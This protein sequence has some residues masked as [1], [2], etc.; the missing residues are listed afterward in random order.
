MPAPIENTI[1]D[2]G[3]S[4]SPSDTKIPLFRQQY[5]EYNSTNDD[6]LIKAVH[7]KMYSD[8]PFDDFLPAFVSKF[9][10]PPKEEDGVIDSFVKGVKG[11]FNG[12]DI[13]IYG[14]LNRIGGFAGGWNVSELQKKQEE[15][16]PTESARFE[17]IISNPTAGGIFKFLAYN[18][19]QAVP[20]IPTMMIPELGGAALG[21]KIAWSAGAGTA[22]TTML[23]IGGGALAS[24]LAMSTISA[25]DVY[26]Q[27][28]QE[29]KTEEEASSAADKTL[30]MSMP[31]NLIAG[32]IQAGKLLK[33][34]RESGIP[35]TD[36]LVKKTV[37]LTMKDLGITTITGAM[38]L[39][40]QSIAANIAL[41]HSW[42]EG[43]AESA[44]SGGVLGLGMG[45]A[46]ELM[47]RLGKHA[48]QS[49]NRKMV[50][51]G[52]PDE[53]GKPIES[54]EGKVT[55]TAEE[56]KIADQR[57]ETIKSISEPQ[58]IEEQITSIKDQL[59]TNPDGTKDRT[60][61]IRLSA[62][63]SHLEKMGKNRND[64]LAE[65]SDLYD[66]SIGNAEHEREIVKI[67]N[68][69][70]PQTPVDVVDALIGEKPKIEEP[71]TIK[72]AA[73]QAPDGTIYTGKWHPAAYEEYM[74]DKGLSKEDVIAE[75]ESGKLK[76]GF[77]TS[78]NKFV[79]RDEAA[80][81]ASKVNQFRPDKEGEIAFAGGL[82]GMESGQGIIKPV[83]DANTVAIRRMAEEGKTT[84]EIAEFTGKTEIDIRKQI[85]EDNGLTNLRYDE[86][87]DWMMGEY[88][89]A[90]NTTMVF[91]PEDMTKENL[92]KKLSEKEQLFA[93]AENVKKGKEAIETI[94]SVIPEEERDALNDVF[95]AMASTE[96]LTP[97]EFIAKRIAKVKVDEP[98]LTIHKF[99]MQEL[100]DMRHLKQGDEYVKGATQLRDD[101]RAILH[102]F[103]KKMPGVEPSDISTVLHEMFHLSTPFLNDAQRALLE[104]H[105]GIE[106]A[107]WTPEVHEKYAQMF[108]DYWKKGTAPNKELQP[109]FDRIKTFLQNVYKSI[110]EK[111]L[112]ISLPE[113]VTKVFDS[114][115]DAEKNKKLQEDYRQS[116][117]EFLGQYGE[118]IV[119]DKNKKIGFINVENPQDREYIHNQ[120]KSYGYQSED[121]LP[122]QGKNGETF[123]IAYYQNKDD[124]VNLALS[125]RIKE[126][127]GTITPK[128]YEMLLRA[129]G[130]DYETSR[131]MTEA[132]R[133]A[134]LTA[135]EK[136]KPST[137]PKTISGKREV[138]PDEL[139]KAHEDVSGINPEMIPPEVIP[140]KESITPQEIA[141]MKESGLRS[142]EGRKKTGTI[143]DVETST[144]ISKSV[145]RL[146]K[147]AESLRTTNPELADAII[148]I[149]NTQRDNPVNSVIPESGVSKELVNYV[150]GYFDKFNQ[151]TSASL[152]VANATSAE[153]RNRLRELYNEH[154]AW[155]DSDEGKLVK[156]TLKLDPDAQ[157]QYPFEPLSELDR[158][159]IYEELGLSK[160]E[161]DRLPDSNLHDM[162]NNKSMTLYQKTIG[163]PSDKEQADII[164][165]GKVIT[166]NKA[167]LDIKT[168]AKEVGVTPEQVSKHIMYAYR[169]VGMPQMIAGSDPYG[170]GKVWKL[171]NHLKEVSNGIA[172]NYLMSPDYLAFK[173]K[174]DEHVARVMK[175]RV[176]GTTWGV[177][178]YDAIEA[179]MSKPWESKDWIT[180]KDAQE[181]VKNGDITAEDATA[182]KE[183]QDNLRSQYS[184]RDK[185]V[186]K[187]FSENEVKKMGYTQ[188]EY[189]D[190][191]ML[192]EQMD[193]NATTQGLVSYWKKSAIGNGMSVADAEKTFGLTGYHP[194]GR[195]EGKWVL[196]Y[197]DP[198]SP[199]GYTFS[200]FEHA[201]TAERARLDM[202]DKGIVNPK[203][204][205]S[206]VHEVQDHILNYG[207]HMNDHDLAQLI[208]EAG[209]FNGIQERLKDP[210][211]SEEEKQILMGQN[212]L[213][214]AIKTEWKKRGYSSAR[215]IPRGNVG[216]II[217]PKSM[218]NE[219][220]TFVRTTAGR[221]SNALG[222]AQL[223]GMTAELAREVPGESYRE[224][225][226]R[227]AMAKYANQYID[228]VTRYNDPLQS[229]LWDRLRD[230]GFLWSLAFNTSNGII[231]S[232]QPLITDIPEMHK[233]R[234][235]SLQNGALLIQ[236]EKE[237]W[238]LAFGGELSPQIKSDYPGLH[239]AI[240]EWHSE[241]KLKASFLEETVVPG[242]MP[243]KLRQ[244]A[245]FPQSKSENKNRIGSSIR[246]YILASDQVIPD[247]V[248]NRKLARE[249]ASIAYIPDKA[250]ETIMLKMPFG[251]REGMT[252]DLLRQIENELYTGK[253]SESE[254]QRIA[255]KFGGKFSDDVN[256]IYGSHNRPRFITSAG[257][258]ANPLK[259]AFLFKGFTNSYIGFFINHM[260][261]LEPDKS[262]GYNLTHNLGHKAV[263]LAPLLALAGVVGLPFA[264]DIKTALKTGGVTD[265]DKDLRELV[266]NNMYSD[267]ILKGLPALL[268]NDVAPDLS[269][270]IGVGDVLPQGLVQGSL[271]QGIAS[272]FLGAPAQMVQ[273]FSIESLK[274]F[275][276]GNYTSAYQ[277][278][279]PVFVNNII[280]AVSA[281]DRGLVTRKGEMLLSPDKISAGEV[282]MQGIGFSPMHFTEARDFE[283]TMKYAEESRKSMVAGFNERLARAVASGDQSEVQDVIDDIVHHNASA[284]SPE[285]YY[286]FKKS[287]P[288][289]KSRYAE[290]TTENGMRRTPK[291]MRPMYQ[292]TKPL[293]TGE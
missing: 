202:I 38:Q 94:K 39:S 40:G 34:L 126:S 242:S 112:G 3:V 36:A 83:E 244:A 164:E 257:W 154:R 278:M 79:D 125:R 254:K 227:R 199:T 11:G 211:I 218:I 97:E 63:E 181:M 282:A 206:E 205:T 271:S 188:E 81:I 246:G 233:W 262:V 228:D 249:L 177:S 230:A 279:S 2:V 73:T 55:P 215:T 44:V 116:H 75:L 59:S 276:T 204:K 118:R 201:T 183:R 196:E 41:D 290:M 13:G 138:T 277:K 263:T 222:K 135:T 10:A 15:N 275:S 117:S 58:T 121:M 80:K 180:D 91:K 191:K 30:A 88:P 69:S 131:L 6:D 141:M 245:T 20:W 136:L 130:Y 255:T 105:S 29:G 95:K 72:S 155:L 52:I 189:N 236:S 134:Q 229:K 144:E 62:I 235:N 51:L 18:A 89:K 172:S 76:D 108:E 179:K 193:G 200:R 198:T 99:T 129:K 240:N 203:D 71:T 284:S 9:G 147:E 122:Y 178:S 173:K 27:A 268:P 166:R 163:A 24:A 237:A 286:N 16:A 256:F 232:T 214:N 7:Q 57:R 93:K 174:G 146:T 101:G 5:P 208:E 37:G 107:K 171:G 103:T 210:K 85:L 19:G 272:L 82:K 109:V 186:G 149:A 170:F 195:G 70:K 21:S 104:K 74:K 207:K 258:L 143:L 77:L 132:W 231:N 14:M 42:N 293:Y 139:M 100:K 162:V 78:D 25:G 259:S 53:T 223:S 159:D 12:I 250:L 124:A 110:K 43:L 114:M 176:D 280:K 150:R 252:N 289:I 292:R 133:R 22:A 266:G 288:A 158:T 168:I 28:L 239:A 113:E 213:A 65:L 86:A 253:I 17:S 265:I 226:N 291:V 46:S 221:Y 287:L 123:D 269:R 247:A 192:V 148:R 185:S 251:E 182:I 225:A 187:V 31:V 241:G 281:A 273:N 160:S 106:T 175:L 84:N 161:G 87:H 194:L 1:E 48:Q 243:E 212:E 216:M 90:D 238:K 98:D 264:N 64:V 128:D 283:E 137:E 145:E 267:M 49:I 96:G 224:S 184:A 167:P 50:E 142:V 197:K 219:Y 120:L 67:T 234:Q 8:T 60:T 209:D 248:G 260:M 261:A 56:L 66:Q 111:A 157:G 285:E 217:D 190:Y 33:G 165:V 220:E 151:L 169:M 156:E 115:L 152:E 119:D 23:R 153:S 32:S 4:N 54:P 45:G 47:G 127:N 61:A 92:A 68:E 140:A 102:L 26:Q 35:V 274:D 270:R